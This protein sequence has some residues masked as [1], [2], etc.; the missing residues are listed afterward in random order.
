MKKLLVVGVIVLLLGL[1]VSPISGFGLDKQSFKLSSDSNILI[2]LYGMPGLSCSLGGGLFKITGAIKNTGQN[3]VFNIYWRISTYGRNIL[4]GGE[5][6]DTVPSLRPGEEINISSKLIFGLGL[7]TI[8]FTISFDNFPK[9]EIF[10]DALI[11]L[12]YIW[13]APGGG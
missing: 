10:I 2:E 4:L 3:T 9:I 7:A 11:L 8:G 5:S 6:S 13:L 1:I 12:F